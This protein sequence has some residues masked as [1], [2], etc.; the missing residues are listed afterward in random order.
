LSPHPQE[1]AA[2]GDARTSS[3][4][5]VF[6]GIDVSKAVLAQQ[7]QARDDLAEMFLKRIARFHVQ[8]QQELE[9]IRAH[10][11]ALTEELIDTLADM[12]R[13]VEANLSD[14]ELGPQVKSTAARHGDLAKL[15]AGCDAIAAYS[16]DNHL[17]LLSHFYR[18]HRAVPFRFART[19]TFHAT[20][21][22]RA[23]VNALQ[24]LLAHDDASGD[25]LPADV[26]VDLAFASEQWQ[27]TVFARVDRRRR[28]ARRHFERLLEPGDRPQ[29]RRY[30]DSWLLDAYADYREH[31]AHSARC[32]LPILAAPMLGRAT[33]RSGLAPIWLNRL[34]PGYSRGPRYAAATTCQYV[35]TLV[36]DVLVAQVNW[37]RS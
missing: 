23:L 16:G 36:C 3:S 19:V 37:Q 25:W 26:E 30:R 18:S 14:A 17:P 4:D 12:L 29:I 35:A 7:I 1:R 2:G 6:V 24:V 27:R 5:A 21:T 22:D 33:I 11:R 20:T 32:Y 15:L 9:L 10:H 28:I 34:M 8:A 13:V 31:C